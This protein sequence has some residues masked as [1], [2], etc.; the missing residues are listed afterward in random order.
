M[1]RIHLPYHSTITNKVTDS[2]KV[3]KYVVVAGGVFLDTNGESVMCPWKR[4]SIPS[5][6]TCDLLVKCKHEIV[7]GR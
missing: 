1:R 6:A 5:P 4:Q 3:H 7:M 2:Q